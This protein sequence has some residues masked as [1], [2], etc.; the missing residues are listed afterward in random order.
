M[1]AATRAM[2]EGGATTLIRERREGTWETARRRRTRGGAMLRRV[3]KLSHRQTRQLRS[4][5]ASRRVS[6]LLQ[7]SHRFRRK[8][9]RSSHSSRARRARRSRQPPPKRRTGTRLSA[10]ARTS[11]Q[12]ALRQEARRQAKLRLR[13]LL[14]ESRSGPPRLR[15][16]PGVQL[17]RAPRDGAHRQVQDQVLR[18]L[19]EVDRHSESRV[20]RGAG[21]T[22]LRAM[23][24]VGCEGSPGTGK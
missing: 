9:S 19:G 5:R 1:V 14:G 8:T 21:R 22:L 12:V 11:R 6:R 24:M 16:L 15:P 10:G 20:R 23:T 7:S 3:K 17:T 4:K 13:S 18:L 2:M